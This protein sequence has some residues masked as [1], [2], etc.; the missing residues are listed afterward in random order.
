MGLV[1]LR[2]V[3]S[4]QT[5]DISNPWPLHLQVNFHHWATREVQV[6]GFLR[7]EP[8]ISLHGCAITLFLFNTLKKWYAETIKKTLGILSGLFTLLVEVKIIIPAMCGVFQ[9]LSYRQ[10]QAY[11]KEN[12][13]MNILQTPP[14][15]NNDQLMVKCVSSNPPPSPDVPHLFWSTNHISYDF[16]CKYFYMHL[17]NTVAPYYF[18]TLRLTLV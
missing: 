11:R 9:I 15:F 18:L 10:F 1:A 5:R 8:P 16:T 17:K 3:E 4:S 14:T 6:L 2:H 7:H 13:G 12:S